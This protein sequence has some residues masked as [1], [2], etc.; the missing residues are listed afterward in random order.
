M[1]RVR[2]ETWDS[3][4][5]YTLGPCWVPHVSRSMRNVGFHQSVP[6]GSCQRPTNNDYSTT[7]TAVVLC[8]KLPTVAVM[9][10]V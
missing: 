4:T 9:V 10:T 6:L 8:V 7:S 1:F 2:C 5:L 3:T